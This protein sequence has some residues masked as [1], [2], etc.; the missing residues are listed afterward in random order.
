MGDLEEIALQSDL[1]EK[2]VRYTLQALLK[3]DLIV[4]ENGM[5]RIASPIF[6]A[7]VERNG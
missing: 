6:E 5:H 1:E 2:T 3:R 4:Q 7:W